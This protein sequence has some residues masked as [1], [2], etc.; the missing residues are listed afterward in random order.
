M[1]DKS[2]AILESLTERVA[3]IFDQAQSSL[4][5]HKKNSVA[6]YKIHIQAGGVTESIK[7]GKATKLIGERAFG[8][9]FISMITRVL[10]VK[11]GPAT[12]DRVVK[13]VGAYVK[14]MNEKVLEEKMPKSKASNSKSAAPNS[15][16]DDT[17]ATRFTARLLKF[18]LQGFLA[19]NK[20]VRYR[21]LFF[22]SEL[23]S[24]LGEIDEDTYN[25]LRD[26]LM[27]R[28]SDKESL[29]RVYAVIALSKLVGT[30]DPSE[31]EEG[32]PTILGVLLDLTCFDD[33]PD[34]RRA[35][36]LNIPLDNSTLDSVLSRTRDTDP[37]TRK[38]VY[39]VLQTKLVHPRQLTIAQREQ[40]V[41]DGLGDREPAVR[42]SA[43]KLVASWFDRMSSE[44]G[45]PDGETW[46]GDDG[47]VMRGLVGFLT[48]FDVVGPGEA[49]AVDAVL[50]IFVTRPQL[51]DVFEFDDEFWKEL[52]P[53]SAILARVF[54]EHHDSEA[55]LE[56][57]A[58]PVVTAFAFR[59][60]ESY[61]ALI[62]IMEE[63]ETARI[64]HVS[65]GDED[66]DAEKRE[67]ELIRREVVLGELLRMAIKLD[68]MD[69]IGR[70]KIFSVVKEML[71][72]PDFPAGL[73]DRCLDVLKIILPDERELIRVLVEVIVD[74]REFDAAES[75]GEVMDDDTRSEIDH[76]TIRRERSLRRKKGHDEMT[77]EERAEADIIDLRCLAICIALLER[78]HGSFEDNSTLEGILTD[79]IIPSVKRKESVLREKGLISLGL[80]C[81]IA[82]NMALS[83][84]Q[85][86]LNQIKVVPAEMRMRVLQIIFDLLTMYPQ[87]FFGRSEDIAKRI[88][89]FL[90]EIFQVE[91]SENILATMVVGFSKL[92]LT[93][94]VTDPTVLVALALSYVNY[95]THGNQELRQCLSYFF[96]VYCYSSPMNQSRMQSIFM[97]A[98]DLF[99]RLHEESDP[100]EEMI[101]PHQFGLL[102]VDW[103]N[104]QKA[105]NI[106]GIE[107]QRNVHADV[108]VDLLRALYDEERSASDRKALCQLLGNLEIAAPVDEHT[109][110]KLKL[111]VSHL[112]QQSPFEDPALSRLFERFKNRVLIM[113]EQDLNRLESSWFVDDEFRDLYQYI[114]IDMP[115]EQ[116]ENSPRR[117]QRAQAPEPPNDPEGDLASNEESDRYSNSEVILIINVSDGVLHRS[118]HS[119]RKRRKSEVN[120]DPVPDDLSAGEDQGE[121]FQSGV[122][123]D[124]TK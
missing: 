11:K 119:H 77:A 34:V 116:Q 104:S 16:D 42:L 114:G 113:F 36:L 18:L 91:M 21:A 24:H 54:V 63:L 99:V 84:F 37:I 50:S 73:I 56:A 41:K 23:I 89:N 107:A 81:L 100:D 83:S 95:E 71:L 122:D 112:E 106:T 15:D 55:S 44:V 70:R 26:N 27:D 102:M 68:Y 80:C 90:L 40:I 14:F 33:A 49:I 92:L 78:V 10:V 64:I 58:L 96:P 85:L 22:V 48:L 1:L 124:S 13:F 52:T 103:T 74:L 43:G 76:S 98:F 88:I 29:I 79:L 93:G 6:L 30:E 53:E 38:V 12:A 59:I 28:I 46:K 72:H 109:L 115:E 120:I 47:G 2:A 61:N 65:G 108:A 67:E 60:Q 32:Q 110:F 45:I 62:E 5:N 69:E 9:A 111:L 7:S 121:P 20:V 57:A 123:S 87:D 4:A 39:S 86:F 3:A 25:S 101:T 117:S 94:S 75:D 105:A 118:Q 17:I 35:A 19:K 66:E 97:Q 8:D 82:K 51:V 31:L